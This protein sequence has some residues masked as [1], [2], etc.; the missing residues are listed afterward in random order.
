M[1]V[2]L[3]IAVVSLLTG[4]LSGLIPALKTSRL[5]FSETLKEGARGSISGRVNAHGVFV[6]IEMALALVL[7]IGAGLMIRSLAALWQVDPGFR[8]DNVLTF[9][10]NLSPAMRTAKPQTIRATLRDLS[11][12]ISSTPGVRSASLFWGGSPLQSENDVSFW[13]EDQPKPTTQRDM[14]MALVYV[15]EPSYLTAMGIPLKQGRFFNDQDNERSPNVVVVDQ[16]FAHKYFGASDPLGKQVHLAGDDG[17]SQIIGVVGHVKQWGLDSDDKQSLRAQLYQPFRALSD[18]SINGAYGVGVVTRFDGAVPNLVDSIRS[19]VQSGN[20][21]NVI[22]RAQTMN[23][24]IAASL[25]QRRFLM[26]LLGAFAAVA[27]LLASLGIYG[28]ISHL[29]DQR[30]HE[31]GIRIALGAQSKDVLRLVVGHGMKMTLS[32]VAVGLVAAFGLTRLLTKMVYGVS[33]TDPATFA[34]I[35][36]LL[37][38]VAL[39]ACIIP[40]RRA[41]KVDPLVALRYE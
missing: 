23:E 27:L 31:L 22:L 25:A 15:V 2:L 14:S 41:T 9:G 30:T 40:A 35:T 36:L 10:L 3:F 20:K 1:R 34:L 8:A 17:P 29:V 7:L 6:A 4:I 13:L 5:R 39:L 18:D 21:Q 19:V 24:V 32:G 16:F 33:A 11:D 12:Q 37:T 28:V 38:A 26:T